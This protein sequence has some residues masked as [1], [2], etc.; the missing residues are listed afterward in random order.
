MGT[1]DWLSGDVTNP[2]N[3]NNGTGMGLLENPNFLQLLAGM[4]AGFGSGKS[5]G[6]AIGGPVMGMIR[7]GQMQKAGQ[8][9]I[10]GL[11]P[12]P[13]GQAG[14][15]AITRNLTADGET[16]TIKSPSERNL[17]TFGT[18]VP[19]ESQV[20]QLPAGGQ[21]PSPFWKALLG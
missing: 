5:A 1:F 7:Q 14:P 13:K 2:S 10:D 20:A 21:G 3:P 12:T 8:P 4:G 6:E 19:A 17:N 11:M 18:S 15:D 9:L 16:I